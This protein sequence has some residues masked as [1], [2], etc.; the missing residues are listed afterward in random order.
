MKCPYCGALATKA[1]GADL[2]P[3]RPELAGKRFMRCVP[4][5][6]MV[7]CHDTS[8]KPLGTLA[9]APLRRARQQAHAAFDPIWRR[10]QLPRQKAYE[11]LARKLGLRRHECH[12]GLFDESQ[13]A[14]VVETCRQWDFNRTKEAVR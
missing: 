2:Y 8:G 10:R 11:W 3:H 6:A 5:D 12:I 14:R 7:G 13:C 1:T 9:N 4:C